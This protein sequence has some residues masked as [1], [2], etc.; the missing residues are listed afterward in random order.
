MAS[1]FQASSSVCV[2]LSGWYVSGAA[3]WLL[4]ALF[5]AALAGAREFLVVYRQHRAR[6]RRAAQ[7]EASEAS[8]PVS[9]M[10]PATKKS[11]SSVVSL[12]EPLTG[13]SHSVT[14]AA[15]PHSHVGFHTDRF[16]DEYSASHSAAQ[17]SLS[18]LSRLPSLLSSD[19]VGHAAVDSG[20]YLLTLALGYVLMLLVMTY[21]VPLCA[22]VVLLSATAHF[23]VN[24]GFT[25]RWRRDAYGRR[26]Q[27][28]SGGLV[29]VG[30]APAV[31]DEVRA[32]SD[33]CCG[34]FDDA[35]FD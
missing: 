31:V 13:S 1:V 11:T 32:A 18:S 15:L 28:Q 20:V 33:P 8:R 21:N 25:A 34:N 17:P 5:V 3:Q 30:A 22:L 2:L 10:L 23:A 35:V 14:G 26:Q 7:S 24:L 16:S 29:E 9:A 19:D 12:S 6:H 4:L 27:Q